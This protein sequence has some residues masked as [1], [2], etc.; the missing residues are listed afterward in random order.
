MTRCRICSG[1]VQKFLDL[2]EQPLSDAFRPADE[3]ASFTYHLQMGRCLT[4][5]AVQ[6]LAEVPREQMF[7]ADYP[8]FSSG[9]SRMREHFRRTAEHLMAEYC[10][11]DGA[12]VVE[13]GCNDGVM[14]EH[15]ARAGLAHLG[16]EPSA[17]VAEVARSR[18]V[19]VT[20]E[21]FD[22][23]SARAH[24]GSLGAADVVYAANTMCHLPY[25]D[26]VLAGVEEIL[27]PQGV[28]VFEDPYLGDVIAKTSF[29]QIYDEHFYLFSAQSV[30][31]LACQHGFELVDV[32]RLPV[33]GGEVRYTLARAGARPVR[34][35]VRAMLDA[36]A[37]SGLGDPATYVAF[38]ARVTAVRDDLL[39]TLTRLRDEGRE[40]VGYG[41][42][43]KSATVLNLAGIGPDLIDRV[44][45]STPAKQ[46]RLTPGSGIPVVAADDF[47]STTADV[48][49][50]FAWNHAEEIKTN[51]AAFEQGGGQWLEYV[52]EVRLVGGR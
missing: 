26:S 39:A 36:E 40:V 6:Q 27:A 42:T 5:G 37:A 15:V 7:H 8:Y 19:R 29:D 48:A 41:A 2:G 12:V 24:L 34:P 44:Y 28:L 1:D 47:A 21:F 23:D 18:G 50:L 33:H 10:G 16:F 32:E 14:L 4:C 43:A 31:G 22:A 46:G 11:H 49:V 35:A 25:L 45:D 51:E 20:T 52:P 9:S 17:S 3:I 30:S 13:I 38:A